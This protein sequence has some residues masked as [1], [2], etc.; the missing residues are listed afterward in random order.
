MQSPFFTSVKII[1]TLGQTKD[2]NQA[3]V[4]VE[5]PVPVVQFVGVI[6]PP[7]CQSAYCLRVHLQSFSTQC[8]TQDKTQLCDAN[9]EILA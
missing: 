1:Q 9:D 2:G 3:P 5:S 6:S 4:L 7:A 8:A